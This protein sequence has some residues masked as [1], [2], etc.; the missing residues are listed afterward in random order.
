MVA[1]TGRAQK[2]VTRERLREIISEPKPGSVV[3]R[4]QI[5]SLDQHCRTFISK[6]PFLTLATANAAGQCDVSPR[7]DGP[8]FVLV[9]DDKTL[10]IPDRPGNRRLDSMENILENPHVG[11]LFMIPGTDETL[12]VNGSAAISE[13]EELLANM[14]MQGKAPTLAII[15]TVEEVFFHCARAFKRSKLWEPDSWIDRSEIPTLGRILA[16]QTKPEGV[17]AE[18][19]D[20]RLAESNKRLY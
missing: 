10:A 1:G 9:I 18:D 6:S 3:L 19:I 11:L 4:K 12:R 14:E 17:S 16:D 2:T 8:G 5:S 13:D 15:V 20:E 7:G